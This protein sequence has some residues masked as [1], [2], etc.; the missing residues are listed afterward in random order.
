MHQLL[1]GVF[2]PPLVLLAFARDALLL[3]AQD[4]LGGIGSGAQACVVG[5]L[6]RGKLVGVDDGSRLLQSVDGRVDA[7]GYEEGACL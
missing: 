4:F 6:E 1:V 5:F 7:V 3:L 2:T